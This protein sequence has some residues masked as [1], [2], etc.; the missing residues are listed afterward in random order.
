MRAMFRGLLFAVIVPLCLTAQTPSHTSDSCMRRT[1]MVTATDSNGP[2]LDLKPDNFRV[3]SKSQLWRVLRA[4]RSNGVGRALLMIDTSGSMRGKE[5]SR[6]LAALARGILDAAPP[7]ASLA[8]ISFDT[9]VRIRAGFSTPRT[10]LVAEIVGIVRDVVS[11]KPLKT[12]LYDSLKQVLD[13]FGPA[14][15]GD[16]IFLISD[17]G[18][19]RS[20]SIMPG[21]RKQL[22]E[23]GLRLYS[24]I[25][26]KPPKELF[27]TEEERFGFQNL[28]ELSRDVGGASISVTTP[29]DRSTGSPET[30]NPISELARKLYL[31]FSSSYE[32]EIESEQVIKHPTKLKV[33][34]VASDGKTWR[35]TK[36]LYAH[37]LMPCPSPN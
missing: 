35:G 4:S 14:Q 19:S 36:A 20:T 29:Q 24:L 11:P 5:A 16:T 34:I 31:L 33:Q 7:N 17:G 37:E 9:E 26:Q 25:P 13:I 1:I 28:D 32:V 2:L 27:V 22:L 3:E 30:L 18:D 10:V 6:V 15:T 12:A 23:R 21:L 8:L